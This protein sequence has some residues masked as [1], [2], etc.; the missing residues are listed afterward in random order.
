MLMVM[1][2]AGVEWGE[3][4]VVVVFHVEHVF[5]EPEIKLITPHQWSA[6]G[7]IPKLPSWNKE[8]TITTTTLS[9]STLQLPSAP[10]IPS[11]MTE[12]WMMVDAVDRLHTI[13]QR[14]T[15]RALQGNRPKKNFPRS[16]L[17]H[18]RPVRHHHH[19]HHHHHHHHHRHHHYRH[20]HQHCHSPSSPLSTIINTITT[21]D[22][23]RPSEHDAP[24]YQKIWYFFDSPVPII[25]QCMFHHHHHQHHYCHSPHH[26][27]SLA[28]LDLPF[29][30]VALPSN[31]PKEKPAITLQSVMQHKA[32]KVISKTFKEYPW[33][34]PL[35]HA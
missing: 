2:V 34:P 32:G 12:F 33:S 26:Q 17:Y 11:I 8:V 10:P 4:R 14:C 27:F 24:L 7:P 15:P 29:L 28:K 1:M 22:G 19:N 20:H 5:K 23:L 25:V 35:E 3:P 6:I 31:F 13:S 21:D 30:S 9:P 18:T 16:G